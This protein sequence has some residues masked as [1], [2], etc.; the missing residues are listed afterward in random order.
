M[1]ELEA[2][3]VKVFQPNYQEENTIIHIGDMLFQMWDDILWLSETLE[4][5]EKRKNK[6]DN[7][8]F[9]GKI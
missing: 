6:G 4:N 8:G 2:N 7:I 9:L 3:Q 5:L 1:D